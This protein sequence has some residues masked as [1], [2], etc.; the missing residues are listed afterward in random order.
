MMEPERLLPAALPE[1]QA[2]PLTESPDWIADDGLLRDEGVIVG[3][4]RGSDASSEDEV[5][6]W[7]LATIRAYYEERRAL[8][9]A[10]LESARQRLRRL[11]DAEASLHKELTR[12]EEALTLQDEIETRL[13]LTGRNLLLA[14]T[15]TVVCGLTPIVLATLLPSD[16]FE[17]PLT[18][19]L[20]LSLFGMFTIFQGRSLLVAAD[21]RLSGTPARPERWKLYLVEVLPPLS[22]A[23]LMALFVY[24]SEAGWAPSLIVGFLV[25]LLLLIPG[26]LLMSLLARAFP[27]LAA[28]WRRLLHHRRQRRYHRKEAESIRQ[29]LQE[30]TYQRKQLEDETI[31]QIECELA[32]LEARCRYK[33][34]LFRSEMELACQ[35]NRLYA[36]YKENGQ[37][38]G[39]KTSS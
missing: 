20:A 13:P 10:Q 21:L 2:L 6:R 12:H 16:R 18:T 31:P 15:L 32:P 24:Q 5:S 30:L 9:K 7:K 38:P 25:L 33:E 27:E 8:L 26:R 11:Q 4:A 1:P 34:A 22:V 19:A 37:I 29:R 39:L 35:R 28:W 14:G 3:L 17:Y 36:Q 23:L